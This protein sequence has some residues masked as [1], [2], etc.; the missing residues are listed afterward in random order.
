M[1]KAVI[2]ILAFL[3]FSI[4]HAQEKDNKNAIHLSENKGKYQNNSRKERKLKMMMALGLSESQ[5]S[6]MRSIHEEGKKKMEALNLQQTITVKEYNDKKSAIRNEMQ[7][8]RQS[9]LTKEQRDKI[10]SMKVERENKKNEMYEKRMAKM[11]ETA[12]L[13]EDQTKQMNALR[14]KAKADVENIKNNSKLN[15][16]EKKTQINATIKNNRDAVMN[17]LTKEQLIKMLEKRNKKEIKDKSA[18]KK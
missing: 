16:Q 6:Q 15:D 10:A 17:V 18:I 5:K 3:S 2:L 11:K 13:T 9:V 7:N 12:G 1:K 8:K 14:Q 4:T